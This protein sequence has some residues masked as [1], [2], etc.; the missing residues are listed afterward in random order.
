MGSGDLAVFGGREGG[1]SAYAQG[2]I[3]KNLIEIC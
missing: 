1:G 3:F 2:T